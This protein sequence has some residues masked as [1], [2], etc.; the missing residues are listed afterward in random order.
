VTW[1]TDILKE[2]PLSAVL[3]ERVAL[4][5]QKFKDIEAANQ[6]LRDQ[7][8][9]LTTENES[10]KRDLEAKIAAEQAAAAKRPTRVYGC[11]QFEGESGLFCPGC[12]DSKGK[13]HTAT[14]LD[15]KHYQCTV[16]RALLGG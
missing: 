7:V 6:K 16:C 1:L 14:R 13:K 3:K 15:S 5:E 2:I 11:Y 10:L 4:A 12:Y 9:T 8:A